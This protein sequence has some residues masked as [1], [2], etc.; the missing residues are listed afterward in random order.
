MLNSIASGTKGTL[1]NTSAFHA[2]ISLVEFDQSLQKLSNQMSALRIHIEDLYEQERSVLKL[3]EQSKHRLLELRKLVDEKELLMKTAE[4]QERVKKEQLDRVHNNKEYQAVYTEISK[5][6]LDQH[7]LEQEVVDAWNKRD[8]AHAEYDVV[9]QQSHEQVASVRTQIQEEERRYQELEQQYSQ[10]K[11][12]R[13]VKATPVP[14]EWIE[15]YNALGARISDPVVAIE[16]D[17]CGGCFSSLTAQELMRLRR[18]ALLQCQSCFRFL[19]APSAM[20]NS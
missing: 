5:L 11:V 6:K 10:L 7:N 19:Y 14:V 4:D 20:G 18:G 8:M 3:A 2:L 16:G 1:M 15:K 13:E 12:E 17:A 9:R